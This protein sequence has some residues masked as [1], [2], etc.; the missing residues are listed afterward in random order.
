MFGFQA[1][2]QGEAAIEIQP[3]EV[4]LGEIDQEM[5]VRVESLGELAQ[6]RGLADPGLAGDQTDARGLQQRLEPRLQPGQLGIL[7]QHRGSFTQREMLEAEV[8]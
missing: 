7:P 3:P 1:Q 4:G 6:D 2:R 8:L 5:A